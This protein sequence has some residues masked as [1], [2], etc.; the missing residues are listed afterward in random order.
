MNTR[1][2]LAA[3]AL[4]ATACHA[5]AAPPAGPVGTTAAPAVTVARDEHDRDASLA[6]GAVTWLG[7]PTALL[8][9]GG[10]RVLT[11]PML[12]G[13]GPSAF[14]LPRHPSTG[15][16]NAPVTRYL[17][18]GTVDLQRLDAVF[19]SHM[20][21]D[22]FDGR[23]K[24]MLPKNLPIVVPPSGAAALRSAGFAD[25]RPLDWDESTT[26]V[27]GGTRLVVHAVAAHHAHDA[28]LDRELGKGNGYVLEWDDGTSGVLR[29]YWTGDA[30]LTED[31]RALGSRFG[32]IDLVM[33]HMG[34]VG[35][36]G[37]LG[38]RTM[39]ASETVELVAA[40]R[41]RR[42]V[43]IHHTTFAHYREPV[44]ALLEQAA[45]KGMD[46][47]IRLPHVGTAIAIAP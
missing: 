15:A 24:E 11:D 1:R 7:G 10:F 46:K 40:L 36:D 29:L 30:V 39:D 12:S 18:P 20:H 23:A 17:A 22:H 38:L 35:G 8:E 47:A 42:V 4:L 27:R 21:A 6:K 41:P 33:P 34:G 14:T 45:E 16:P 13:R 19:V 3:S 31:M 37:P 26:F 44:D 9:R 43:P 5:D 32:A 28:T 25:V 2:H